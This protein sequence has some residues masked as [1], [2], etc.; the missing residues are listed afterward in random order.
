MSNQLQVPCLGRP[1]RLGMLYDS[2]T[3]QLIPGV[4]LWNAEKLKSTVETTKQFSC[5]SNTAVE[6]TL[7]TK[8]SSL[9][10]ESGTKLSAL[11]GLIN[12]KGAAKF[13]HDRKSSEKQCRVTLQFTSTTHFDQ[14][15]MDQLGDIQFPQVMDDQE[16]THVV[17]GL[18]YGANAFLVFDRSVGKEETVNEISGS[19]KAKITRI[20][21]CIGTVD[22]SNSLQASETDKTETDKFQCKFYGD[23]IPKFSPTT[24]DEAL[25]FCKDLPEILKHESIPKLAY[26]M[27]LSKFTG[28][29]D[30]VTHP[31]PRTL[32]VQV[33][34]IM[35]H[36]HHTEVRAH[37][38]QGHELCQKFVDIKNQLSRFEELIVHFKADFIENLSKVLPKIRSEGAEAEGSNLTELVSSVEKSPFNQGKT[39]KYLKGKSSSSLSFLR[40][41]N[42]IPRFSTTFHIQHVT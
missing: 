16:A 11:S 2:R 31:I 24:F 22:A 42:S 35:E 37:D 4:T 20:P 3:E 36:F 40:T 34:D 9:N 29:C 27:P 1:F 17:T 5:E 19:M 33:E 8:S 26:L 18:T 25:K 15:T 41:W 38:L 12:V 10:L 6:D 14:L 7:Q 28:S 32:V 30:Q 39:Q 23:F 21:S 13:L